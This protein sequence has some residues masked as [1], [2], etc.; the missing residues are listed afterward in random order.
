ALFSLAT[1]SFLLRVPIPEP[2]LTGRWVKP[3]VLDDRRHDLA[4]AALQISVVGDGRAERDFGGGDRGDAAG[5]EL[6]GVDQQARGD[7]L[8]EAVAA[9]VPDLLADED[10]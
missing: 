10:E 4:D 6:R 9:K 7:A 2:P 8:F 5:G 3:A 1:A